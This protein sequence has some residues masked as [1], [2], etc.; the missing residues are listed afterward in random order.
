MTQGI[1][2]LG[3]IAAAAPFRRADSQAAE[4]VSGG[5]LFR[6]VDLVCVGEKGPGA[7]LVAT[8]EGMGIVLTRGWVNVVAAIVVQPVVQLVMW[9]E[10]LDKNFL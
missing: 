4:S 6:V 2:G 10:A 8:E 5:V 3:P 7:R 1:D 9:V